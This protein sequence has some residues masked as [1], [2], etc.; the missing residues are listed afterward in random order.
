LGDANLPRGGSEMSG[1]SA[2]NRAVRGGF[3]SKTPRR[4]VFAVFSIISK[5]LRAASTIASRGAIR[6]ESAYKRSNRLRQR[7]RIERRLATGV[8]T[9]EYCCPQAAAEKA[10]ALDRREQHGDALDAGCGVAVPRNSEDIYLIG[11]PLAN[12]QPTPSTDS[13]RAT[14]AL[15]NLWARICP[16]VLDCRSLT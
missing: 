7:K 4:C 8:A 12:D 2:R 1:R 3:S 13:I 15:V 11:F 6:S 10:R 5:L 16:V 9:V 14:A